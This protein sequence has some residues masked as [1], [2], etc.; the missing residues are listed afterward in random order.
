MLSRVADSLYWM[1][2]YLERAEHAA[3]LAEVN[4]HLVLDHSPKDR[5][6]RWHRLLKAVNCTEDDPTNDG[7]SVIASI[8]FDTEQECSIHTCISTARENARQV[9]EQVTTEMFE[10]LNALYFQVR[11]TQLDDIW[12][13]QPYQ[14]FRS[15]RHGVALFNGITESTLNH[16]QGYAFISLGRY[17]ERTQA[18]A[19]LLKV[20]LNEELEDQRSSF[21][22]D[23][24]MRCVGL[25][26]SCDAFESYQNHY[27]DG[28]RA[29]HISEFLLLSDELPRSIRFS[30]DRV[31]QSLEQ[32]HART[33]SSRDRLVQTLAGRLQ[34]QLKFAQ[35]S[36]L[37][38]RGLGE[39]L[40]TIDA[41]CEEIHAAN[42][43]A[44]VAYPIE[45]MTA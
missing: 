2:R 35:P 34:A 9:R 18:T 37:H 39:F 26:R 38:A 13:R 31:V 4:L 23:Q 22:A 15:I 14:F 20:Y 3:R 8:A 33:G 17:L 21:E 43:R 25:L 28:V 19:R 32:V 44:H 1:G 42:Y 11:K 45:E 30:A 6:D 16:G 10:Q 27:P 40:D 36:E 7:K 5:L 41:D 29:D 24:Y 12:N